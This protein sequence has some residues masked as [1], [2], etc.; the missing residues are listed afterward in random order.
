MKQEVI[1]DSASIEK[2][3]KR[4]EEESSSQNFWQDREAANKQLKYLSNLK[5]RIEPLKDLSSRLEELKILCE[6]GRQENDQSVSREVED[7]LARLEKEIAQLEFKALLSGG[8]DQ[9]NAIL[10]IHPGAGGTESCDWA[11][12]LLRM[13]TRW[14]KQK[15]YKVEILDLFPGEEAGIKSAT[16][17]VEGDYV[18]GYLKAEKGVHRLVRISPFDASS[19]RHTSF[20]S[21]WVMPEIEEIGEVELKEEDL[22]IDT[23]RA[24]GA[25]GQHVN[26]TDSAVRI[27]HIPTK[28]VVQCQSDRSQHKN[29]ANALKVLCARLYEY[30]QQEK[31][32]EAE[33]LGGEKKE[34]A[35]G[36]QI[37][38]YVFH[39]YTMVKDHRTNLEIGNGKAVLDGEI[40]PF[41]EAYLKKG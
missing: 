16:I 13:Y 32:K 36:S 12:M 14:A 6:L 20:A 31:E 33:K 41:I 4:L 30:Y 27:T 5:V 1:F 2:E 25:G 35:W 28:I 15:G 23:Y 39:P 9:S 19:H 40:N 24:S 11:N 37:R 34:I 10:S 38:S 22:R 3:I 8:H 26:V 18:Y 21:V 7:G 29:K 17:F